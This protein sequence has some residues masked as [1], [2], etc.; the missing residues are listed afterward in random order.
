[1]DAMICSEVCNLLLIKLAI[2]ACLFVSCHSA[3]SGVQFY[4][5]TISAVQSRTPVF[6]AQKKN[7]T[8]TA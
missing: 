4:H 3:I 6:R 8:V 5:S 1:M 2:V 7:Q